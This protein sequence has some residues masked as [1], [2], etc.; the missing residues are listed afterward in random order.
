MS[1]HADVSRDIDRLLLMSVTAEQVDR[2]RQA[3]ARAATST[4]DLRE[5][6]DALGLLP[7]AGR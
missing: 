3:C 2:A 7:K 6:L 4:D 5:L 1:G